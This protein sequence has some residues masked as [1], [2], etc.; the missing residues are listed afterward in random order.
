M[1]KQHQGVMATL[2]EAIASGRLHAITLKTLTPS[3]WQESQTV[4][5]PHLMQIQH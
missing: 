3:Q 4:F 1:V 2:N 5:N